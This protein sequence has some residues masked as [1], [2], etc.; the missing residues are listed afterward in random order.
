MLGVVVL[1]FCAD[2]TEGPIRA[3]LLDVAD[4]E[5]QD[6]ALNI[7]AAS[8]GTADD[9]HSDKIFS[10]ITAKEQNS[11]LACLLCVLARRS[12]RRSRLRAWRFGLDAHVPRSSLQVAGADPLLLCSHPL[13]CLRRAASLKYR[14]AAVLAATR[15]ARAGTE[16]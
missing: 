6:M 2:A 7:H 9:K 1:D 15:Q 4:T 11:P 12:R 10:A 8:A 5:E 16:P 13:L 3:Y 14:G